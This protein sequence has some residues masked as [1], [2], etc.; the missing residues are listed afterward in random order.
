[1]TMSGRFVIFTV[2]ARAAT[3]ACTRVVTMTSGRRVM[4]IA[5]TVLP[6]ALAL[7][8]VPVLVLVLV[9]VP[10]AAVAVTLSLLALFVAI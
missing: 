9:P 7:V 1:M 2:P 10:A 3:S 8:L 5:A 6:I 4:L